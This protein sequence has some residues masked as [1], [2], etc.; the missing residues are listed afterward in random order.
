[1]VGNEYTV[2]TGI[3]VVG[4]HEDY[5]T[6]DLSNGAGEHVGQVV[7]SRVVEVDVMLRDFPDVRFPMKLEDFEKLVESGVRTR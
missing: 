2:N 3:R 7:V 5:D 4:I 6:E 1:M